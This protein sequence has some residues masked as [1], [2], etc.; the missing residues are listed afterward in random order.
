MI[1]NLD[2]YYGGFSQSSGFKKEGI[3]ENVV[4]I[5]QETKKKRSF[6]KD[7]KKFKDGDE[8]E[9]DKDLHKNFHNQFSSLK[10]SNCK[11]RV[12]KQLK[13][14]NNLN[15]LTSIDYNLGLQEENNITSEFKS[16]SSAYFSLNT[17]E[18]ARSA[19][20]MGAGGA[21][22]IEIPK[23]LTKKQ[24][25]FDD[26]AMEQIKDTIAKISTLVHHL[27]KTQINQQTFQENTSKDIA[28]M[29]GVQSAQS[30][31][32]DSIKTL[33]L[34]SIQ[35]FQQKFAQHFLIKQSFKYN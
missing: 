29:V 26:P 19:G 9:M 18:P 11:I 16:R 14:Q 6:I 12:L 2:Y 15:D 30:K 7:Y 34:Q 4:A 13:I 1:I 5:T 22:H 8:E 3:S 20:F 27:A 17:S 32:L 24:K 25:T 23:A 33:F 10:F 35:Y 31:K 21:A 28:A